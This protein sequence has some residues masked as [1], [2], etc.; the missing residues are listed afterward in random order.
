MKKKI[1]NTGKFK[2]NK[3]AIS[4][5]NF[6]KIAGGNVVD[7]VKVPVCNSNRH[8]SCITA[9]TLTSINTEDAY[10]CSPNADCN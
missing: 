4:K 5:F 2:L 10:S 9:V 1:F 3:Q 8:N 6:S 7:T